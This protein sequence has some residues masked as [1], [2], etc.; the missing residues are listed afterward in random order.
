MNQRPGISQILTHYLPSV[1]RDDL[2]IVHHHPEPPGARLI[3]ILRDGSH[4]DA[5]L[6]SDTDVGGRL[7]VGCADIDVARSKSLEDAIHSG[8]LFK[9]YPGGD[10]IA[11]EHRRLHETQRGHGCAAIFVRRR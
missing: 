7:V 3:A 4:G 11:M 2:Q 10:A 8:V 1:F 5:T 9:F 6:A